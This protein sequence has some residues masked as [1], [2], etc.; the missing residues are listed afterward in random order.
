MLGH[1]KGLPTLP[2]G[3]SIGRIYICMSTEGTM[4]SNCKKKGWAFGTM[5]KKCDRLVNEARWSIETAQWDA[6]LSSTLFLFFSTR[7]CVSLMYAF[8]ECV[9]VLSLTRQVRDSHMP[10]PFVPESQRS[11]SFDSFLFKIP[12]GYSKISCEMSIS[13]VIFNT[14]L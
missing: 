9:C 5:G 6:G 12:F 13:Y 3:K 14:V 2:R 11:L 10:K 1:E 7:M 4:Y 8:L